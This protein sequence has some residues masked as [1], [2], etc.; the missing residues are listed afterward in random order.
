MKK[1]NLHWHKSIVLGK[2]PYGRDLDRDKLPETAGIY[3]F[4]RTH[5]GN[6]EALYVGKAS[7][8][9]SRIKQ[10]LNNLKLMTGIKDAANG[11][12]RLVCA[13]LSL[14]QGQKA[15][16]ALPVCETALIRYYLGQGHGLLNVQGARLH[17]H[18]I[19]SVR[20]D[21]KRFLPATTKMLVR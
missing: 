1:L 10:Q 18:E 9:R 20:N 12:K 4:L 17:Y 5:G 13:E 15:D 16:A 6:A 14:K 7:N 11:E 19:D 3:L 2:F 8:L 21:L